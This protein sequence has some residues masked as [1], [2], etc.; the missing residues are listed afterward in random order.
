MDK[1]FIDTC[2][3]IV[4]P[5]NKHVMDGYLIHEIYGQGNRQD[6]QQRRVDETIRRAFDGRFNGRLKCGDL[7]QCSSQEAYQYA[8][9]PKNTERSFELA[10]SDVY[11][12]RQPLLF[13]DTHLV[14]IYLYLLA[15][16]RGALARL[17]RTLYNFRPTIADKVISPENKL[18]F[19][20]LDQY[21]MNLMQLSHPINVNHRH[22]MESEVT[23][24]Q[25][26]K[27]SKEKKAG[28]KAKAKSCLVHYL[29]GHYGLSK[30]FEKY[31][32]YVPIYGDETTVNETT[33]PP[34]SWYIV[35]TAHAHAKAVSCA[36]FAY[37]PTKLR[38]AVPI[39]KWTTKMKAFIMSTFYVVDSFPSIMEIG[40]MEHLNSWRLT[41]GHILF[42]PSLTAPR[43]L[44]QVEEHFN[45]SDTYMDSESIHKL[46]QNGHEVNDFHDMLALMAGS[47]TEL[48]ETGNSGSLYGKYLDTLRDVLDPVIKSI[49][50]TKY[51]LLELELKNPNAITPNKIRDCI[52]R[53][54]RTG[55]IFDNSKV[56]QLVETVSSCTD[57]PYFK[58]TSRLGVADRSP[59]GRTK[60]RL[61]LGPRHYINTSKM[62]VGSILNLSKHNPILESHINCWVMTDPV[63]GTIMEDPKFKAELAEVDLKLNNKRGRN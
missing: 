54:L 26:H 42:S 62:M 43:I 60:G 45:S 36:E 57:H 30:M 17:S 21:R 9:K 19:V 55:A 5:M 15:P 24:G 25:I 8:I 52:V 31:V 40:K 47:F 28:L 61:S 11:L 22:I 49:N 1:A 18:I 13:D 46:K 44:S 32:G 58:M 51:E 39:D 2:A 56:P 23:W 4:P 12:V 41:L 7:V 48:L 34:E 59:G 33:Y 14:D 27:S 29:L 6:E 37:T 20:R 35:K 38:M 3:R 50:S 63:T 16:E 10:P 53:N